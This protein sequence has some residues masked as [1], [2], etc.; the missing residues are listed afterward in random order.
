MQIWLIPFFFHFLFC[1]LKQK[2]YFL[3][4]SPNKFIKNFRPIDNF[5]L[6]AIKS[7]CNFPSN[8]GFSSS[9]WSI[10][11]QSFNMLNTILFYHTLR[12]P[13]WIESSPKNFIKFFIKTTN[14]Q[15]LKIH[16]FF[17]NL[18][19]FHSISCNFQSIF[20]FRLAKELCLLLSL[21]KSI[22]QSRFYINR[23]YFLNCTNQDQCII[24]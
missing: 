11:Q 19:F 20:I 17:K 15:L 3:F 5:W 9:R 22:S 7:I 8:Q 1:R 10:Q 12:I 2:P 21:N 16:V 4:R 18:F 14:S 13:S 24:K 23:G 6:L